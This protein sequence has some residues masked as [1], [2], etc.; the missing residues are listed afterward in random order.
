MFISTRLKVANK[1]QS[2]PAT[3]FLQNQLLA[4]KMERDAYSQLRAS[5][6]LLAQ[7]SHVHT[8]AKMQNMFV[9]SIPLHTEIHRNTTIQICVLLQCVYVGELMCR[10]LGPRNQ[11]VI[12]STQRVHGSVHIGDSIPLK[13]FCSSTY[14]LRSIFFNKAVICL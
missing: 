3:C 1:V 11:H 14:V 6:S 4:M 7:P 10:F 9:A 5:C 8:H 13:Y 2:V 12:F